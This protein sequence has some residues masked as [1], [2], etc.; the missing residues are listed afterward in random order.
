MRFIT[1]DTGQTFHALREQKVWSKLLYCLNFLFKLV[2]ISKSYARK[3][4]VFL[5]TVYSGVLS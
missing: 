3:Q 4:N 1:E 5:N 2:D